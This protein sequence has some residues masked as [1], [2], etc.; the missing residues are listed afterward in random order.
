MVFHFV[1]TEI[2]DWFDCYFD[3]FLKKLNFFKSSS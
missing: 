2:F 1:K 3:I